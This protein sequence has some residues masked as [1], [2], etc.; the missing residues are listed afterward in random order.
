MTDQSYTPD[1]RPP[2]GAANV[3]ETDYKIGQHNIATRL[4]PVDID[5]HKPVFLISGIAIVMFTLL[6]LVLQDSVAPLFGDLRK[7]L[8]SSFDWFFLL[9]GNIFL[10]LCLF[11]KSLIGDQ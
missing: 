1:I 10:L 8:T 4:G 5:I 7:F 11:L 3:I 6:V 2:D 9:S